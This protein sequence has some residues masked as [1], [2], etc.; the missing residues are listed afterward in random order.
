MTIWFFKIEGKSNGDNEIT[1]RFGF[2]VNC[3]IATDRSVQKAKES[4]LNDLK[5]DGYTTVKI[6]HSGR[7]KDFYWDQKAMQ[8]EFDKLAQKAKN[9]PNIVQYSSFHTWK[10]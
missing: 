6:E 4:V 3:F 5:A 9:N 1:H 7:Y 10:E 8:K 2:Y